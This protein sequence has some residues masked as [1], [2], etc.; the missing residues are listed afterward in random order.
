MSIVRVFAGPAAP[1]SSSVSTTVLPSSSR[2]RADVLVGDLLVLLGAEAAG[3][4]RRVV[5]LVQLAEVQVE[6]AHGAVELRPAR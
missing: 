5:G 1:S 2:R 3:L 6:V 4:D